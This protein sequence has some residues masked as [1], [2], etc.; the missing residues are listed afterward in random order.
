MRKDSGQTGN[1]ALYLAK[2]DDIA[3]LLNLRGTDIEFNPVFMAYLILYV[4]ENDHYLNLYIN[5]VKIES[6]AIQEHLAKSR[7]KV[8]DYDEIFADLVEG[9]EL[10]GRTIIYD[11][12]ECSYKAK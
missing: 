9:D 3:W 10:N 2:L 7:V 6:A 5:S 8:K 11:E 12:K 4:N 1:L